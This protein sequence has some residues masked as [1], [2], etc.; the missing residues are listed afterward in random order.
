MRVSPSL[1]ITEHLEVKFLYERYVLTKLQA[2][3]DLYTISYLLNI[4]H[5]GPSTKKY[6]AA[7]LQ[8]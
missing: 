5:S 7:K 2:R 4:T 6:L 1:K 3:F 8:K